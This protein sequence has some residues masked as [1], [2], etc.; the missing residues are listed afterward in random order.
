MLSE[1]EKREDKVIKKNMATNFS[2]TSGVRLGK[3]YKLHARRTVILSS[4]NDIAEKIHYRICRMRI[5]MHFLGGFCV[6][7]SAL[8]VDPS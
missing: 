7:L 5:D 2:V 6:S 4:I 3:E 8:P 1:E